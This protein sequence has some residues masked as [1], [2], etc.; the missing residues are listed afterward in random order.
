MHPDENST[1]TH[2]YRCFI[3]ILIQ[4]DRLCLNNAVHLSLRKLQ[5][6]RMMFGYA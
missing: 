5:I 3:V 1:I 6:D 2:R 4:Q